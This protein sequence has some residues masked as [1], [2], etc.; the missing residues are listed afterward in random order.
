[1]RQVPKYSKSK[2]LIVGGGNLANHFTR[3]FSLLNVSYSQ[4]TRQNIKEFENYAL[5]AERILILIKDDQIE[6]FV[7]EH[8]QGL[9]QDKIWIHCSGILSIKDAEGAHP[10]AS[11]SKELFDLE[12]YKSVPFI[13]EKG[14]MTFNKLFP[15]LQNPNF[16]I[17]K[18]KKELY[19][20]WCSMAG[21][22]TTIL[23]LNYFQFL[24]NELSIPSSYA[25]EFL[26]SITHNLLY[27]KDP[28]TGPLKRRDGKTIQ[29]HLEQLHGSTFEEVYKS[30]VKVFDMKGRR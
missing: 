29:T 22:F 12:F 10:L 4:I 8:R 9:L 30:F 6:K 27:S 19:H 24:E 26:Y 20:A 5:N 14:R 13:T 11:F 25:M 23:W 3:Y 15:S 18:E 1:M 16:S 21:N 2:Y 28:L 7:T 17:P